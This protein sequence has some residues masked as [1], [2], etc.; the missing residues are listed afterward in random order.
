MGASIANWTSITTANTCTVCKSKQNGTGNQHLDDITALPAHVHDHSG[1][2]SEAN[3]MAANPETSAFTPLKFPGFN[4]EGL[5][6]NYQSCMNPARDF[7]VETDCAHSDL[8]GGQTAV[9]AASHTPDS[10][11]TKSTQSNEQGHR[12][13]KPEILIGRG[14]VPQVG[15]QVQSCLL[16]CSAWHR[17]SLFICGA[18]SGEIVR[19]RTQCVNEQVLQQEQFRSLHTMNRLI[20]DILQHINCGKRGSRIHF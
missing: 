12:A 13:L 15:L 16:F 9:K 3:I 2:K 4:S 17:L 7:H 19:S 14:A 20:A 10:G 18:L 11:S 1:L 6:P 5:Q 8:S